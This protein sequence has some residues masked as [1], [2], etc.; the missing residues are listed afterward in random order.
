MNETDQRASPRATAQANDDCDVLPFYVRP[1]TDSGHSV[2]YPL[3]HFLTHARRETE[4]DSKRPL[5]M[6][7]AVRKHWTQYAEL[8]RN[9]GKRDVMEYP[10]QSARSLAKYLAVV[11]EVRV[12]H[13]R[14]Y[15]RNGEVAVLAVV[16]KPHLWSGVILACARMR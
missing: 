9:V 3:Y 14:V 10:Q 11:A 15:R 13:S 1:E 12:S 16:R 5:Q 7:G 8:A 6:D 4:P 2:K